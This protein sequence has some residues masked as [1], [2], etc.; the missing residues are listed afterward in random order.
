M[1]ESFDLIDNNGDGYIQLV[2]LDAFLRKRT[3]IGGLLA[4]G[5]PVPLRGVREAGGE[6][7][8]MPS[9]PTPL[10]AAEDFS[11]FS[12]SIDHQRGADEVARSVLPKAAVIELADPEK[13]PGRLRQLLFETAVA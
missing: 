4:P 2:E 12:T 3:S 10:R 7:A 6:L 8:L 13:V 11:I 5:A 1:D 9:N